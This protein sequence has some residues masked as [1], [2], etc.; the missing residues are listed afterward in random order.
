MSATFLIAPRGQVYNFTLYPI[1]QSPLFRHITMTTDP[2]WAIRKDANSTVVVVGW[3]KMIG[4]EQRQDFLDR[5]KNA[6]RTVVYF[7]DNDSA[8][9][10][11]GSFFDTFDLYIK[12][13]VFRDRSMYAREFYGNRIFADFYHRQYGV[14][15]DPPQ[16]PFVPLRVPGD[17]HR[18]RI[19]WNITVGRYPVS[20]WNDRIAHAAV[21]VAG[22][23][24]LRLLPYRTSLASAPPTPDQPVCHAR[25]GH[26][27][28]GNSIGYQRRVLLETVSGKNQFLSGQV[29]RDQYARELTSVQAVL[30]PFGWGEICYRDAE[31]ILNGAVLV[32]P[33]MDHIETWPNVFHPGE[34]Y[35]PI[36][37]DG[38][39]TVENVTALLDDAAAIERYR[40]AA[41]HALDA[42]YR[43]AG[44][45][46]T[47]L[48]QE[49]LDL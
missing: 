23:T 31:A 10:A 46:A 35:V 24:G 14:T 47:R 13:Q 19:A 40:H 18:L 44:D 5:L 22:K 42:G 8:E 48:L 49:V 25:F 37:W 20:R 2:D 30:S 9:I 17:T 7:D 45:R 36:R 28:Y 32:K 1:L 38:S 16:K 6:Y 39:D 3:L 27:R 43:S 41:W 33:N 34:T 26:T 15:D 21:T 4:K 12:K 11:Y 29:P